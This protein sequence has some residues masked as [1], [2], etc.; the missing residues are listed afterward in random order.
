MNSFGL[1]WVDFAVA[2]LLLWGVLRGRKRGMSEEL[3]DIIK[4][5]LIVVVAGAAY[6]P[7]G[8]MLA[9]L[10]VF[11]LL[12]SYL[13]V[14]A[15]IAL[16]IFAVFAFIRSK[17]GGKIAGAEMFGNGE[18]YLGMMAGGFRYLC[19]I[20]VVMALLNARLYS[21]ADI[22][23]S[24]KYQDDNFGSHFFPTLPDIQQ[25]VFKSSLC[26]KA[27]QNFIPLVLIK[28]TP[29]SSK[30]IRGTGTR[31]RA[32]ELEEVLDHK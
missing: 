10:S 15:G 12:S 31:V 23:A 3:L 4:W 32:R 8:K 26:G 29:S 21:E 18:Y 20:L 5:G 17:V 22:R 6:Q 9:R 19:V 2:L 30:D 25:Q 13:F 1:S 24:A 16:L 14:Y 11:S 28:S 7:V 27:V